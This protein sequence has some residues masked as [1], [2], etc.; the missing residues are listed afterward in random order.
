MAARFGCGVAG[1][2]CLAWQSPALTPG[3]MRHAIRTKDSLSWP[4]RSTSRSPSHRCTNE[5][6]V[7]A[8]SLSL[9]SLSHPLPFNPPL[10]LNLPCPFASNARHRK[11]TSHTNTQAGSSTSPDTALG[12][13]LLLRAY[14]RGERRPV[15]PAIKYWSLNFVFTTMG[16]EAVFEEIEAVSEEMCV[17]LLVLEH[18]IVAAHAFPAQGLEHNAQRLH[19]GF[20]ATNCKGRA[21]GNVRGRVCAHFTIA[22]ECPAYANQGRRRRR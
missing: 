12:G 1:G 2:E 17:L 21:R 6:P 13:M 4:P 18:V 10:P 7:S 11:M 14:L 19:L 16:W 22:S 5:S 20:R 8:S 9:T 3:R 15:F